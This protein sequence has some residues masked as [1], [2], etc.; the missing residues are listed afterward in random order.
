MHPR[1]PIAPKIHILKI[2]DRIRQEMVDMVLILMMQIQTEGN[3]S[4]F[5]GIKTIF[6]MNN[7]TKYAKHSKKGNVLFFSH[8]GNQIRGVSLVVGVIASIL[9]ILCAGMVAVTLHLSPEIDKL[10]RK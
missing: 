2:G 4:R 9:F 8:E 3:C 6:H 10:A 5:C 1:C 7:N